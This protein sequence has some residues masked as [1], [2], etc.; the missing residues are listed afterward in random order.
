NISCGE[1]DIIGP[2]DNGISLFDLKVTSIGL[3]VI[4]SWDAI[5]NSGLTGY[6]IYRQLNDS[7]FE[8]YGTET[9]DENSYSDQMVTADENYGYYITAELAENKESLPSDTVKI[10]PGLTTTWVLDN[11]TGILSELTHD[12][13]HK[14][15]KFFNN[16]PFVNAFDIDEKNGYIYLLN[17][18]AKTLMLYVEGQILGPA[19]LT[20][21][22]SVAILFDD[23]SDI[24]YDSFRDEM[25][26]ADGSSGNIYHYSQNDSGKW[27]LADSLYTGGSADE[28][29]IDTNSGDY[30]VVNNADNSVEIYRNLSPG[31]SRKS[32]EGFTSEGIIL[33]LDENRARAYAIDIGTGT[34]SVIESSGDETTLSTP[35][36]NN[37]FA[38]TVDP[39]SGDLWLLADDNEDRFYNLIKLSVIGL[40]IF[41]INT[42]MSK[43]TWMGVNPINMNVV[44]LNEAFEEAK[45][46]TYDKFGES[47]NTFG[48]FSSPKMARILKFD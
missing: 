47:I 42:G 38:A 1:R 9:S 34:V 10:I 3:I 17:G 43:P 36:I 26:L 2:D 8:K 13:A 22:D 40:R 18:S 14:T 24:D 41:D 28:G 21:S 39:E 4:L 5:D 45:V 6:N 48:S 25:W 15:G 20:D 23:P 44:V 11:S 12:V 35:V 46:S 19:T 37:I 33:A 29:Q 31:Y 16:L 7:D 27:V 30:W 32:I